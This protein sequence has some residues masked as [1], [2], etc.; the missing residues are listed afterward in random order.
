MVAVNDAYGNLR[1]GDSSTWVFASATNALSGPTAAAA[2]GGL[3]GF[4]GIALVSAGVDALTFT[5]TNGAA[6]VKSASIT[7]SLIGTNSMGQVVSGNPTS[8]TPPG[9]SRVTAI[10]SSEPPT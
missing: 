4:S 7:V 3:A 1:T 6:S 9:V 2:S 5:A 10:S 8:L